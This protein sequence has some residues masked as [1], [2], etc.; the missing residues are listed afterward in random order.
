MKEES[1]KFIRCKR[2]N[3]ILKSN[4]AQARGYGI[5]CYKKFISETKKE[6]PT[7]FN[8]KSSTK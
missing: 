5:H 1:E 6:Q 8:T 3:R 4:D 2:C 7:L